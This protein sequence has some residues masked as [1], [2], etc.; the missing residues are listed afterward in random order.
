MRVH[1]EP[2]VALTGPNGTKPFCDKMSEANRKMVQCSLGP[3]EALGYVLTL[4][5]YLLKWTPINAPIKKDQNPELANTIL[6]EFGPP[7]NA[8]LI[9]DKNAN[10]LVNAKAILAV[11]LTL[12]NDI[13][14]EGINPIQN[15]ST[16]IELN[17][18]MFA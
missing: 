18:D 17:N 5:I 3:C 16:V 7:N 2:N 11:D 1:G 12:V 4:L 9:V 13:N 10:T 6:A 14:N 15:D 8:L